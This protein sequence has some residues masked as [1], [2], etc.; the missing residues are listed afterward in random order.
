MCLQYLSGNLLNQYYCWFTISFV[1]SKATFRCIQEIYIKT[2][3]YVNHF[4]PSMH[5][6]IISV[7]NYYN[8]QVFQS[9]KKAETS[10]SNFANH[11]SVSWTLVSNFSIDTS[12]LKLKNLSS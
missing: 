7:A 1:V 9:I 2:G 3:V 6:C 12:S 11:D 4:E 8:R 10:W 5:L